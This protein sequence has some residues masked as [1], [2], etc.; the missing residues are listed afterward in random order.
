MPRKPCQG[1]PWYTILSNP[2]Y[3]EMFNYIGAY[4]SEREKLIED[5]Q[6]DQ[7]NEHGEICDYQKAIRCEQSDMVMVLLNLSIIPNEVI[8]T[9]DFKRGWQRRF[10]RTMKA[11]K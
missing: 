5:G 10:K 1:T 11:Y 4:T 3:V 6:V 7:L 8:Q 2:V 9:I